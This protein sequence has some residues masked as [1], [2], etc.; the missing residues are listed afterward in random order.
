MKESNYYSQNLNL[1][2]NGGV[3]T[4]AYEISNWLL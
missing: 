2:K 3:F 1:D 4:K